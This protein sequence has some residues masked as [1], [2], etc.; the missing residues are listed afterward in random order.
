MFNVQS[1]LT[2]LG[3]TYVRVLVLMC[4]C[5]AQVLTE[6]SSIVFVIAV[7]AVRS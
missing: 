1:C 2:I 6:P 7:A 4:Y 5:I 3:L